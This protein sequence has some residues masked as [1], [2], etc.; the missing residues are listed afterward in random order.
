M[1]SGTGLIFPEAPHLYKIGD[2][3]YLLLAEGGTERG[4]AVSIA[5]GT[6]PMGPFEGCPANTLLTATGTDGPVQCSGHGDLVVGPDGRWWLVLLGVWV[7]GMTR[8]FGSLGRET[9]ITPIAWT[10][11]GWPVVTPPAD[12]IRTT[13]PPFID[14]FPSGRFHPDWVGVRNLPAAIAKPSASVE[15]VVRLELS[16]LAGAGSNT[17]LPAEAHAS[18][19]VVLVGEGRTMDDAQPTFIGRRQTAMTCG[20]LPPFLYW[21]KEPSLASA[22]VT[23]ST[24]I[25]TWNSSPVGSSVEPCC[26]P[27]ARHTLDII[28][29]D[30]PVELRFDM[31]PPSRE[32]GMA[33]SSDLIDLVVVA[34]GSATVVTTL[35]RRYLS[36][37]RRVRLPVGSP[38]IYFETGV[39]QVLRVPKEAYDGRSCARAELASQPDQPAGAGHERQRLLGRSRRPGAVGAPPAQ[40]KRGPAHDHRLAS[41]RQRPVGSVQQ[42]R[43]PGG[44]RHDRGR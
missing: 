20:L 19:G 44:N 14:T 6:S 43:R 9:Y 24:T 26:R 2:W 23:T 42:Q 8:S 18:S 39:V 32:Y 10:E 41:A 25:T 27:S 1:W 33:M 5:R 36:P 29:T 17:G 11:E 21:P 16:V 30:G 38:G 12:R 37:N 31:R 4:H 13:I 28:T 3:W 40:P 34:N 7:R 22:F 35:D 15:D